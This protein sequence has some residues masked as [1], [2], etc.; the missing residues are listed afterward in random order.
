MNCGVVCHRIEDYLENRLGRYERQC[1][2]THLSSCPSC[3][4]ELRSRTALDQLLW[5]ALAGSVQHRS[6]SPE[7]ST[8]M[9]REA[10]DSA[11][12]AVWAGRVGLA[13][14]LTLST[15]TLALVVIGLFVLV[16]Q[17]PISTEV[18]PVPLLPVKQLVLSAQRP[19]TVSPVAEPTLLEPSVAMAS[20]ENK[21]SLSLSPGENLFEPQPLQSGEAFTVTV[22]LSSDLA[23]PLDNARFD[24]DISGP[25]G[26]FHFPL[27]V[28]G[29]VPA[30]G[31]S[32]LRVTSEVLE[33]PC[34]EKYLI[35][36]T[37][38]FGEPGLYT[39]RVTLFRQ[40]SVARK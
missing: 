3:S 26:S 13:L 35:A 7:T 9:V 24:V 37:D 5:M 33:A 18:G 14:R 27:I 31:L 36:P 10:Q 21:P 8:R 34:Q 25:S 6:L 11:R 19:L 40:I 39:L 20:V 38:I 2:E 23:E 4:E 15:V 17:I 30:H 1:F 12:R 28:Q 16:G 22:L 29:P 32:V